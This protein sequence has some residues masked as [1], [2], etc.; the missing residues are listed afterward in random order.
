[1]RLALRCVPQSSRPFASGSLVDF[2]TISGAQDDHG[3]RL[4][5]RQIQAAQ[6]QR[7]ACPADR[8]TFCRPP[9]HDVEHGGEVSKDC[10]DPAD[11]AVTQR[12]ITIML[13][14]EY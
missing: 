3:E 5:I 2:L 4:V 8:P 7:P 9:H 10:I 12:V 11:P 14:E 6:P 1:M 13:A